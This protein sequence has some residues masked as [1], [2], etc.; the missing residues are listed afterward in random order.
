MTDPIPD[1]GRTAD[2]HPLEQSPSTDTWGVAEV[3]HAE[4][5]HTVSE[6]H[7]PPEKMLS[8]TSI[9]TPEVAL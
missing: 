7:E 4:D 1:D 3:N 9:P 8:D 5:A 6:Y 2:D